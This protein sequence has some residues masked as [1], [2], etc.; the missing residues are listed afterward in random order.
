MRKWKVVSIL[1]ISL[2]LQGC[3]ADQDAQLLKQK[4]REIVRV[5]LNEQLLQAATQGEVSTVQDILREDKDINVQDDANKRTAVMIATYNND[6][7]MARMLI[8][9]GADVNIQDDMQNNPFLYA[10]AE[11][12]LKF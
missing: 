12:I 10:G 2:L 7:E 5:E 8:E 3:S 9:A 1:G 4:D 6:V 11:A